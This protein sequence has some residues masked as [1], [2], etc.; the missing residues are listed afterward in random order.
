MVEATGRVQKDLREKHGGA[1]RVQP[2]HQGASGQTFVF[3]AK[4]VDKSPLQ[5]VWSGKSTGKIVVSHGKVLISEV[6]P[7]WGRKVIDVTTSAAAS[8]AMMA[9]LGVFRRPGMAALGAA[10]GVAG[11]VAGG[12][13]LLPGDGPSIAQSVLAA[14]GGSAAGSLIGNLDLVLDDLGDHPSRKDIRNIAPALLNEVYG[15][16]V[17]NP[18]SL[19]PTQ[20]AD[21]WAAR[22][23]IQDALALELLEA[24]SRVTAI[25][26]F[27]RIYNVDN[28]YKTARNSISTPPQSP[29]DFLSVMG[30]KR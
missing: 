29:N 11:V 9:T 28:A 25:R 3:K 7:G 20:E 6:R 15:P 18:S 14:A 23:E 10:V 8:A 26:K 24:Y 1:W 22:A 17:T 13:G 5:R 19:T 27:E 4:R 2:I 16:A 12:T 30:V 21:A